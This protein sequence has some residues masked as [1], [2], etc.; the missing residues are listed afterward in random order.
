[1]HVATQRPLYREVQPK[2]LNALLSLPDV[3]IRDPVGVMR[4][5][6]VIVRGGRHSVS[7][8]ADFNMTL[9]KYWVGGK[10]NCD[11]F[12]VLEEVGVVSPRLISTQS[13]LRK[14]YYRIESNQDLTQPEKECLLTSIIQRNNNLYIE[15]SFTRDSLADALSNYPI[16]YRKGVHELVAL[17]GFYQIPMLVFTAGLGDV[18]VELM[19]AH[20]LLHPHISF[21]SNFMDFDPLPPHHIC[22]FLPPLVHTL[23]K[24]KVV[25]QSPP[26]TKPR[27]NTILIG[28]S[29]GDIQ[30]GAFLDHQTTLTIGL[31]NHS[32][33]E[34]LA[35]Y[36]SEF[37][38]VLTNDA[39]LDWLNRLILTL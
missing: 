22:G 37:D 13:K 29:L 32:V 30:M 25:L 14:E 12:N 36:S 6:Q 5:L 9:T 7:V 38:V 33:E 31:L 18:V 39:S 28:D 1:M 19:K 24:G 8:I 10:Q 11:T 2:G 3:A 34:N 27:K 15:E 26:F 17:T 16:V 21:I 35:Q 4:K 23:N 20:N